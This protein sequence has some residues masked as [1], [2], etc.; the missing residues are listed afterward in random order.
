MIEECIKV[1]HD[2]FPKS[3]SGYC[4]KSSK[5]TSFMKHRQSLLNKENQN[6]N[7]EVVEESAEKINQSIDEILKFADDEEVFQ[8]SEEIVEPKQRK[9]TKQLL[10]SDNEDEFTFST[11]NNDC[12]S[13]QKISTA[14]ESFSSAINFCSGTFSET[15]SAK[16]NES[17]NQPTASQK[18]DNIVNDIGEESTNPEIKNTRFVFGEDNNTFLDFASKI[19]KKN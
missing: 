1:P 2:L 8:S 9:T 16:K 18:D 14:N 4:D 11:D 15:N 13:S 12:E 6:G 17:N 19:L 7:C 3:R 5:Y 10:E